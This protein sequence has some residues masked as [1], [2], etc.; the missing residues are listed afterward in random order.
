M[1][2]RA[3]A[4]LAPHELLKGLT[5]AL[6][7]EWQA[8]AD[9][10]AHAQACDDAEIREALETLGSIEREHAMS[11]TKRIEA[12]GGSPSSETVVPGSMSGSIANWLEHDLASE[13]W[14]IVEYARIV[15]CTVNDAET[16]DLM[17]EL[18]LDEIRHATW[19]KATLNA[20]GREY[21]AATTQGS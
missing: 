15:A 10:G 4:T 9:Y 12:L 6:R 8:V 11:L 16:V 7:A 13:Q 21:S 2:E 18:L 5:K 14:A 19:L 3:L 20:L 1:E 17:I